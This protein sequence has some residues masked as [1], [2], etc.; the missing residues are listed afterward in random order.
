MKT[1]YRAWQTI[2]S[3]ILAL[4]LLLGGVLPFATPA[5]A[6]GPGPNQIMLEKLAKP[7]PEIP[8][9]NPEQRKEIEQ[10]AQI[11]A[12]ALSFDNKGKATLNQRHV[13]NLNKEQSEILNRLVS[14]LNTGNIGIALIEED[15]STKVY[16]S[17]RALD[18]IKSTASANSTTAVRN[19]WWVNWGGV[20]IYVDSWWTAKMIDL[21]GWAIGVVIGLTISAFCGTGIGCIAAGLVTDFIWDFVVWDILRRHFPESF[22]IH[23]PWWGWVKVQTWRSGYWYHGRTFK[24][25]LWT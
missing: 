15:G 14:D 3:S 17:S 23:A 22:T 13:A 18:D 2:L 19:N 10:F 21:N 6:N 1:K 8:E 5:Y 12:D 20:H 11:V 7:L 4:A 16:G 25:S 9:L 24:S